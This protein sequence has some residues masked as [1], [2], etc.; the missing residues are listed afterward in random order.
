MFVFWN[1]FKLVYVLFILFCLGTVEN[2]LLPD[3]KQYETGRFSGLKCTYPSAYKE[4]DNVIL[5]LMGMSLFVIVKVAAGRIPREVVGTSRFVR[6]T[7]E[8]IS[9]TGTTPGR[10]PFADEPKCFIIRSRD[11]RDNT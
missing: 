8:S 7:R 9:L 3:L 2:F 1:Q 4:R 6:L 10:K 11:D 5:V